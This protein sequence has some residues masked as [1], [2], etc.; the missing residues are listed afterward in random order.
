MTST[1]PTKPTNL[2]AAQRGRAHGNRRHQDS[3]AQRPYRPASIH[4]TALAASCHAF[5]HSENSP[6]AAC[7]GATPRWRNAASV[8]I[9]PRGVRCR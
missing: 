5:A 2:R 1:T 7:G 8:A 3:S 9:R 4:P 6:P